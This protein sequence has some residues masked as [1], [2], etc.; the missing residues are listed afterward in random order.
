MAYLTLWAGGDIPVYFC[1]FFSSAKDNS[2]SKNPSQTN[3]TDISLTLKIT[4]P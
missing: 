3:R 2:F 1:I 4:V